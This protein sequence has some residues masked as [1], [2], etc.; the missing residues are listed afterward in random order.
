MKWMNAILHCVKVLIA[1][2]HGY[3]CYIQNVQVTASCHLG[4]FFTFTVMS[5]HLV[6]AHHTYV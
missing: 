2:A 3:M 1:C 4:T 6:D 5:L